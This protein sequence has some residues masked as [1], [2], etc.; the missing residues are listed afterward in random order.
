MFTE[1]GLG[2]SSWSVSVLVKGVCESERTKY[3]VTEHRLFDFG[4][5]EH[6][7]S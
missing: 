6:V 5:L 4:K 7:S 2:S 1:V 3:H